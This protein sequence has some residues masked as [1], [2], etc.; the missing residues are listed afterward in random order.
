M[1]KNCNNCGKEFE[2]KCNAQKFCSDQCKK[3]VAL[4]AGGSEVKPASEVKKKAD[5][6]A[7]SLKK[8]AQPIISTGWEQ[9][10]ADFCEKESITP[11]DLIQAYK[12]KGKPKKP[13][14][15]TKND[16]SGEQA[17]FIPKNR[18]MV[19]PEPGTNAYFMRYGKWE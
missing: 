8:I 10:I 11:A 15:E 3:E 18:Q 2:A 5:K 12:D 17:K 4:K 1:V 16:E 9:E 14:K 6:L 7:K 19:E 13:V